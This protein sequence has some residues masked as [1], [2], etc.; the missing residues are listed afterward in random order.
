M[1]AAWSE[2]IRLLPVRPL[3]A[4]VLSSDGVVRAAFGTPGSPDLWSLGL[5]RT[6]GGVA[7]PFVLCGI[8]VPLLR[9]RLAAASFSGGSGRV[10]CVGGGWGSSIPA[11]VQVF[12]KIG[13]GSG[14]AG[15]PWAAGV[16]SRGRGG[17]AVLVHW[18]RTRRLR[19]AAS[20]V[21][22]NDGGAPSSRVWLALLPSSSP[23]V[24]GD[25]RWQELWWFSC[26][27]RCCCACVGFEFCNLRL[28]CTLYF[29]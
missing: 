14:A 15:L 19:R 23:A 26:A 25:W 5:P 2:R 12:R 8:P 16:R 29:L 20:A 27:R 21:I 18:A 11:F 1:G 17:P 22:D 24:V 4:G 6:D 7:L 13:G 10:R 3:C 28:Y 9:R